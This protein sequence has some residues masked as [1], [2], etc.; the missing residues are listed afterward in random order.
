MTD[1]DETHAEA[2][3]TSRSSEDVAWRYFAKFWRGIPRHFAE[4]WRGERRIS[5]AFWASV[6]VYAA[7]T[8]PFVP[9]R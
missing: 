8:I 2:R 3:S 1:S 4:C 9:L 7:A 6:I 5:D